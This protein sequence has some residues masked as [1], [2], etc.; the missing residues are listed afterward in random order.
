MLMIWNANAKKC[1]AIMMAHD[2]IDNEFW[3]GVKRE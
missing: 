3:E 1:N 2:D